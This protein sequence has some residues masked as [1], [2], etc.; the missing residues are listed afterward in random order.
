MKK[1]LL[2]GASGYVGKAFIKAYG[3]KYQ[4]RL[5][6]RTPVEGHEFVQGDIKRLEDLR[7]TRGVDTIIHFATATT[8]GTGINELEYFE[9]K[10]FGTINVLKAAVCNKVAK[11][12]YGSSV[13]AVGFRPTP[14]LIKETD[15]CEPSDG[16]YGTSKYLSERLCETYAG[17]HP[18][19]IIC[20]RSA[21]V[22]PQHRI[23]VPA[24]PLAAH[25]L[26]CVHIEDLLKAFRLAEDNKNVL[27]VLKTDTRIIKTIQIGRFKARETIRVCPRCVIQYRSKEL[28]TIVPTACNFGYDILSPFRKSRF[29]PK[30]IQCSAS[31][32]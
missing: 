2:T 7:A 20:L 24:N 26:G 8:D 16:M 28:S 13:C 22:V 18:I 32:S 11:V 27:N 25:W 15:H 30:S 17:N 10:T 23:D 14:N 31:I 5:F 1:I 29:M 19:D 21:M 6:G 9:T 4:F 12:V 3:S